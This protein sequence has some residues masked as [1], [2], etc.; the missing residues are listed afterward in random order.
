[1]VLRINLPR[2][3][4]RMVWYY[5]A[6]VMTQTAPQLKKLLNSVAYF[7]PQ[8]KYHYCDD[9]C[10]S[11][12]LLL[13][14]VLLFMSYDLYCDCRL[15]REL[16]CPWIPPLRGWLRRCNSRNRLSGGAS[17]GF[18]GFLRQASVNPRSPLKGSFEGD[19]VSYTSNIPQHNMKPRLRRSTLPNKTS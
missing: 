2:G 6:S 19:M 15:L 14:A 18:E 16:W 1:M 9:Y 17:D 4:P 8:S 5:K 7:R 3:Y 10:Y 12:M 13:S 11:Y